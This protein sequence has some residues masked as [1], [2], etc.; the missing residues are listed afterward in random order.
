MMLGEMIAGF[1]DPAFAAETLLALDDLALAART[2]SAAAND[3]LTPGEFATRSVARFVDGAG[4]DEWLSLIGRMSRSKEPSE[5]F[6]RFILSR[7]VSMAEAGP[8]RIEAATTR[9]SSASSL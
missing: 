9:E 8:D 4:D 2:A 5:V 3:G 7:A 6:L 1:K